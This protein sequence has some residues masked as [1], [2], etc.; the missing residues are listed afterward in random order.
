MEYRERREEWNKII[1]HRQKI[2]QHIFNTV[3]TKELFQIQEPLDQDQDDWEQS[4][5]GGARRAREREQRNGINTVFG[6]RGETGPVRQRVL[7][8]T[9]EKL[10]RMRNA[11][12]QLE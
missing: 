9:P 1:D 10:R 12:K 3:D 5:R 2:A 7:N 8:K 6:S 4:G 11:R